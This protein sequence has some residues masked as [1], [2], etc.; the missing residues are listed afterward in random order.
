MWERYNRDLV[1]HHRQRGFPL[2]SFDVVGDDY[3]RQYERLCPLLDLPFR[4]E[5]ARE[6]YERDF[7]HQDDVPPV[8]AAARETYDYLVAHQLAC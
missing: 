5:A 8:P 7:V 4:E 2:V 3:V 1:R 6:F